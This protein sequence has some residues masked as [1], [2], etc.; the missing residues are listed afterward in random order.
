[1]KSNH[2]EIKETI[3]RVF[4]FYHLKVDKI[5][6]FGS[7]SKGQHTKDSDW[8]FLIIV[9]NPLTRNEKIDISYQI[10]ESLAK[11]HIPCDIIIRSRSE[12]ENYTSMVHSVTKTALEEGILF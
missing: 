4:D 6:F 5:L 3:Y 11:K 1:M 2:R 8:D 7:R 9:K 10:R 12:I